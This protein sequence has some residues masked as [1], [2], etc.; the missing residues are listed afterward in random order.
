MKTLLIAASA[1]T[2]T[3]AV[4][5]AAQTNVQYGGQTNLTARIGQLQT[6]LQA[7]LQAGAI[8]RSEAPALRT[9][10]RS[11][12]QLERQYAAGGLT[13]QERADLQQRMRVLRQQ[14]RMAEGNRADYYDQ[15]Y[16]WVDDTRVQTG[17]YGNGYGT[18]YYNGYPSTGYGT[19]YAVGGPYEA[20]RPGVSSGL[21]GVLGGVLGNVLGVGT[22]VGGLLGSLFGVPTQL[23]NTYRDTSNIYYRSD[24]RNVYGIDARTNTVVSVHPVR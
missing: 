8:D 16:G 20:V 23:Q 15:R 2:A 10:L 3:V 9:Q 1:L 24:G 13:G 7:G 19:G 6:R 21:G 4:P 14:F 5:A 11:L 12:R 18:G 22:N 17:Y